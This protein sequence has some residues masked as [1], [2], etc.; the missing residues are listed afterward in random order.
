MSHSTN[1]ALR[2]S[3]ELFWNYASSVLAQ[4]MCSIHNICFL[5]WRK[6]KYQY[7]WTEKSILSRAMLIWTEWYLKK[8]QTWCP[9]HQVLRMSFLLYM[10]FQLNL[11]S[12]FRSFN[13][14]G[15]GD[16]LG[17]WFQISF[18]NL[19]TQNAVSDQ[20]FHCLQIVEPFFS[21][22]I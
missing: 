18:S 8:K 21:R 15:H 19:K 3:L 10:E 9:S 20:G 17:Y 2:K 13:R 4:F 1:Y 22:N 5:L 7:F 16:H 12:S 14:Y 11:P 6:K